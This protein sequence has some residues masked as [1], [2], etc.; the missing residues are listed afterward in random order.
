MSDG[1]IIVYIFWRK[2]NKLAGRQT[3]KETPAQEES[4]EEGQQKAAKGR[5][6]KAGNHLKAPRICSPT[7]GNAG[8][9]RLA[10]SSWRLMTLLGILMKR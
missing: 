1:E 10:A 4:A 3:A 9:S 6:K 7:L 2:T 8:R 5:K